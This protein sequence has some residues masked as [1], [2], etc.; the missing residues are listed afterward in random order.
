MSVGL[1]FVGMTR[2]RHPDDLAFAPVPTVEKIKTM[3]SK[4]PALRRRLEHDRHLR[5]MAP[6]AR[7][8]RPCLRRSPL[9]RFENPSLPHRRRPEVGREKLRRVTTVAPCADSRIQAS[10]IGGGLK[11]VE[12]YTLR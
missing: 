8:Q 3:I 1:L 10:R 7:R 11:P 6:L 12:S 4:K 5:A 9:R 2:V